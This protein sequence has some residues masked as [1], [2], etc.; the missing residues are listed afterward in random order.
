MSF[1]DIRNAANTRL[2]SLLTS[3]TELYNVFDIE[4]NE[5]RSLEKGYAVRFGEGLPALACTRQVG[6]ETRLEVVLTNSL[7]V[8]LSDGQAPT[9]STLYTDVDSVV[10]SF[11]NDTYLGVSQHFKG[12]TSCSVGSP[13]LIVGKEFVMIEISFN[14]NHKVNISY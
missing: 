1:G 7:P 13:Q 6:F 9:V 3:Y 11:F 5:P 10:A 2:A 8:R 12:F 4:D 14:A